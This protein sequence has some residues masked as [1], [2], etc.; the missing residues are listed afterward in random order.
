PG[1]VPHGV[2]VTVASAGGGGVGG[3]HLFFL[4]S[5][6]LGRNVQNLPHQVVLGVFRNKKGVVIL[7][8]FNPKILGGYHVIKHLY[9]KQINQPTIC[10]SFIYILF[11]NKKKK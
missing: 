5:G 10:I 6:A 1:P 4:K 8:P 7:K 9:Y 11:P 3:G 2:G